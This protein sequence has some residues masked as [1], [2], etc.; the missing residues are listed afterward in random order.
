MGDPPMM[1]LRLVHATTF[2]YDGQ[3][4]A[5][6]NE[7]R[8]TPRTQPG[9][10]V[11][12]SRFEVSPIPWTYTYVDYF[13]TL[14]TAFEVVDPHHEMTIT[15][16][17]TV[18][19]DRAGAGEPKLGWDGLDEDTLDRWTEYLSVTPLVTPPEELR[20]RVADFRRTQATPTDAAR[21]VCDVINAEVEYQFGATGVK[22]HA[23]EA[24]E[25]RAGV[26][27]DMAHLALGAIRG[28]GIPARY[29]S[30]YL[31]PRREPLVGVTVRGESH[32]WIEWWDDGWR[33]FDPTNDTEPGDRYVV[34]ATGRD[35]LDVKPLSGLYSG[36]R[37]DGL[38][39]DVEITRLA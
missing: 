29:V 21:A 4:A 25:K 36:A 33:G 38:S 22:S 31:H 28:L 15:A 18:N 3:A 17:S 24:W 27:Q 37:T 1:Q 12:H 14:V 6:Y 19:V 7:A 16:T 23:S 9:Q 34:V 39:V 13:D 30:G 20:E 8:M 5:S 26:C 11:V 32:A 2:A 35:Y 10:L